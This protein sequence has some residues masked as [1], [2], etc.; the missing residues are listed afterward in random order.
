MSKQSLSGWKKAVFFNPANGDRVQVNTIVLQGSEHPSDSN[1][2]TESSD[3]MVFGGYTWPLAVAFLDNAGMAMLEIWH[4]AETD[5][6]MVIFS[7]AGNS[8]LFFTS[9]RLDFKPGT[10]INARDGAVPHLVMMETT[11]GLPN[12]FEIKNLAKG[13]QFAGDAGTLIFPLEGPTL[14]LAADY[15]DEDGATMVITAKDFAGD[16]VATSSQAA[17]NGRISTQI[18]LPADTY[19]LDIDLLDGGTATITNISL[20]SDGSTE[21][22]DY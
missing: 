6:Q 5:C 20:R 15:A 16:P 12:V 21:F 2:K 11:G 22:I 19:S 7:P 3:G 4:A 13:I 8:I 14:T 1:I 9:E 18:T 10:G 17:E